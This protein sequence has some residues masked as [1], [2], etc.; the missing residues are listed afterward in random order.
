MCELLFRGLPVA[1]S[2]NFVE[3]ARESGNQG[4]YFVTYLRNFYSMMTK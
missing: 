1:S 2:S 3:F 4:K